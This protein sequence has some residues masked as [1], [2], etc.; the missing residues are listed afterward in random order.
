MTRV[1]A[2]IPTYNRSEFID[3]A[4]ET[5]LGQTYDDVEAVVVDDGSTDGTREILRDYDDDGRVRV[6]HNERNRGIAYS[7]NRAAANADGNYLCILGDDDRWHPRKVEKQVALM[8]RLDEEYAVVRTWGLRVHDG[9]LMQTLTSDWRGDIYPEILGTF[10]L[11]PHSSHMIRR[12][13]FEAVDGFDTRFDRAVDW[14]MNIR[15]AKNYKFEC[16]PEFLTEWNFHGNN[17]S[18]IA[19]ISPLDQLAQKYGAEIRQYPAVE[20]TFCARW[21]RIRGWAALVRGHR[22]TSLCHYVAAFAYE[23]SVVSGLLVALSACGPWAF[24]RARHTRG[25][26]I[27]FK[28]PDLRGEIA[29]AYDA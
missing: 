28:H 1:S 2:L 26:F 23:P 17:T 7:F 8:D 25:A 22:M 10:G 13:C 29:E 18:R 20:R 21:H 24:E 19:Y 12:S 14:E 3:G 5:V 11:E 6:F 15:L 27:R 9:T 16:V 4:I